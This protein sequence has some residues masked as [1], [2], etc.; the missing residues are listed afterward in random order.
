MSM[1]C[2]CHFFI[3]IF[4]AFDRLSLYNLSI[5]RFIARYLTASLR[6][7]KVGLQCI[8]TRNSSSIANKSQFW[9]QTIANISMSAM[10]FYAIFLNNA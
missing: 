4:V 1:V 8:D 6:L 10:S 9:L 3:Y 7:F 5:F 2:L